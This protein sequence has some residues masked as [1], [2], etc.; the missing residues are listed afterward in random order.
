[1]KI[2]VLSESKI[3]GDNMNDDIK[4]TNHNHL[5]KQQ[6]RACFHEDVIATENKRYSAIDETSEENPSNKAF[7]RKAVS[8]SA[9]PSEKKVADGERSLRKEIPDGCF[10]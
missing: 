9:M 5:Q 2:D 3:S 4:E 6:R 10:F 8:F 1:M 7:K